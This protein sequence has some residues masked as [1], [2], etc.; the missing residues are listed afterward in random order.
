MVNWFKKVVIGVTILIAVFVLILLVPP[1]SFISR[2]DTTYAAKDSDSKL[3]LIKQNMDQ[4]QVEEIMGKPL[5]LGANQCW[6]Y[7]KPK[8]SW[9]DWLGWESIRVCFDSDNRVTNTGI[10]IFYD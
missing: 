3:F 9:S 8:T 5:Y 1:P 2:A 6:Y 4:N 10:N 7:S